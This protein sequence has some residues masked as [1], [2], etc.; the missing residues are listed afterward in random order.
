[1]TYKRAELPGT[2]D[3]LEFALAAHH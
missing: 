2:F 3:S 1:M